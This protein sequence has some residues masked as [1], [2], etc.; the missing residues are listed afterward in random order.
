MKEEKKISGVVVPMVT[1][2]TSEFAI[3]ENAVSIILKSLEQHK[4]Y[5]FILG[6]TG[7]AASMSIDLQRK[8][9]AI[10]AKAKL[11]NT[12]LY[13]GISSN[14][15]LQAI[16]NAKFCADNNVDVVVATV[17]SYFALTENQVIHYFETVANESP[18]P[19][20]IYNIPATTHYS[21]P[22][23]ILD[24]L[25]NHSN[26]VGIK[27]SERNDERLQQSIA[28]WKHRKDCSFF[29]GW[30]AKSAVGLQLGADGIIPSTGNINPKL[31]IDLYN[32]V[33][34]NKMEEANVLQKI[35]DEIGAMYQSNKTLGES[36]W[37]LKVLMQQKGLC[38][39]IVLPPL[40]SLQDDEKIKLL[41][42]YEVVKNN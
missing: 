4:I 16:E 24:K 33:K 21:I 38:Q 6:T 15:T 30:A 26:I 29:V 14:S 40:L 13:T 22:I 17:P 12:V 8:M 37:A 41:T 10:V 36:L 27:D 19:V 5:P 35:S 31:Y 34:N 9:I 32:A 39:D 3:D 2:F 28:L 23:H 1:P 11:S 42:D 25:S 7:E 20:I 18:L